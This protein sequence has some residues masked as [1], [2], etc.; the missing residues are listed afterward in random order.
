MTTTPQSWPTAL[1]AAADLAGQQPHCPVW[2]GPLVLEE[3]REFAR[4][5][6]YY[7]DGSKRGVS[8]YLDG[9]AARSGLS[10]ERI[11]YAWRTQPT[12]LHFLAALARY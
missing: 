12:L 7:C 4:L 8:E 6:P 1:Q 9:V 3:E 2:A 10:M 11:G 5:C